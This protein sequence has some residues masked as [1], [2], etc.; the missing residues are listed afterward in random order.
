MD[1]IIEDMLREIKIVEEG[2][3]FIFYDAEGYGNNNTI[4][5]KTPD[6]YCYE[7]GKKL[8][9]KIKKMVEE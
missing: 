2:I 5:L 9:E 3:K 6:K 4:L 7:I 8:F 1:I